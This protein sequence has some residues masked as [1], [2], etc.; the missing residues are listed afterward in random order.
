[1]SGGEFTGTGSIAEEEDAPPGPLCAGGG[2]ADD[3]T[4]ASISEEVPASSAARSSGR[5][6]SGSVAEESGLSSQ[7]R[8]Q[9]GDTRGRAALPPP[10]QPQV[11]APASSDDSLE[12]EALQLRQL[13][14][15]VEQA[16]RQVGGGRG[17]LGGDTPPC[18][19]FAVRGRCG[20][21]AE[22]KDARTG[23]GMGGKARWRSCVKDAW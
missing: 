4:T 17:R 14:V 9:G 16:K 5:T 13:Q 20:A 8:A 19:V 10:L 23:P 21:Q 18:G 1:M 22:L 12:V 3:A 6:G 15:Q 2:A 11:A 7:S